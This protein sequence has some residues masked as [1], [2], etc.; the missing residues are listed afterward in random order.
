M[1]RMFRRFSLV[2]VLVFVGLALVGNGDSDSKTTADDLLGTWS[3]V[4]AE[5]GD[6]RLDQLNGVKMV[7]QPDGKRQLI[8][9]PGNV[10][11]G[12]YKLVGGEP[13]GIDT[14][15]N[16]KTERPK[17]IYK[18]EGDE[19]TMVFS[20]GGGARPSEFSSRGADDHLLLI[21]RRRTRPGPGPSPS[22][23]GK[24]IGLLPRPN[25]RR[26]RMGI[27]AF[28]HD[29][30]AEAALATQQFAHQ[31]ADIIAHHIEGVPWAAMHRGEAFPKD[32]A[33]AM[34]GKKSMTPP[35]GKVYLAISPGRGELKPHD[36]AP[37]IPAELRGKQYSD[38]LVQQAYLRYCKRM[39]EF[40]DPDYLAIGIEV[41]EIWG[42][43]FKREWNAYLDLHKYVYQQL[44]RD[45]PD[46][47]IFASMT[48]HTLYNKQGGMVDA[49]SDLVPYCD[50]IGISYYPF[51]VDDKSRLKAFDWFFK[52]FDRYGKRYAMV[53]TNAAA[54]T[55]KF[56]SYT[57]AGTPQ[58][59]LEYYQYLF[60]AAQEHE[61]LFVI[62]FIHRDYDPLW[63]KIKGSSPQLFK[64][65]MNCGFLDENGNPRPSYQLWKNY[66]TADLDP[67]DF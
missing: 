9:G 39:I 2:L 31:N 63:E 17:G 49:M 37:E 36:K 27:T 4:R 15:T 64:A 12:T 11:H 60:S 20:Q 7:L 44:K 16:G 65:W 6:A 61:F 5:M 18:I 43:I 34:N 21:L 8:L 47:P 35:G 53:E 10:E 25:H 66:F 30:T 46:L 22:V 33:E 3:I 56:D 62:A 23:T 57:V 14:T 42:V 40:F 1:R 51:F 38:P 50:L 48:L 54:E 59:Q 29:M 19:L 45:H 41:N 55:T 67:Q 26:F 28:P 32:F 52:E 13:S 58:R 24:P